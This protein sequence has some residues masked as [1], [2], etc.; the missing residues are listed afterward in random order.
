[1]LA[2][3]NRDGKI[4]MEEFVRFMSLVLKGTKEEKIECMFSFIEWFFHKCAINFVCNFHLFRS[5]LE[6][7]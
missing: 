1:M 4:D 3:L 2:D 7:I 5:S 6:K